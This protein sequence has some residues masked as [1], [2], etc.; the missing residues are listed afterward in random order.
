MPTLAIFASG[1]GSNAGAI[2]ECFAHED[3]LSIGLI[4]T[5]SPKAGVLKLA[6]AHNIPTHVTNR[7]EFYSTE[8]VLN[9]LHNHQIDFIALAGFLWLVPEVLL[10]A[11]PA[12]IVNIHPALLPKYGGKGMFG[13][14]VHEAVKAAG[15]RESG[16]TIHY[17]DEQYDNGEPIFQARVTLQP[18]DSAEAIARKVL[19]LEH[20]HYP[21]LLTQLMRKNLY[22]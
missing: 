4:L 17:V 2:I 22:P 7:S 21:E 9:A 5:N 1:R 3:D 13:Q 12:R 15:D 6:E 10:H 16:I 19:A 8:S 14:K 11:F 18:D 20:H